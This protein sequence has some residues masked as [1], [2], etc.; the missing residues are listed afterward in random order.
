MKA[1]ASAHALPVEPA[2]SSGRSLLEV[3]LSARLVSGTSTRSSEASGANGS[4]AAEDPRASMNG[5][6]D[7]DGV[8]VGVLLGL[9]GSQP[10]LT[11]HAKPAS[12]L[13]RRQLVQHYWGCMQ[14]SS[15]MRSYNSVFVQ[16]E[17]VRTH[18]P[19]DIAPGGILWCSWW[20]AKRHKQPNAQQPRGH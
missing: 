11:W 6:A 14:D 1:M 2:I 17:H 19:V 7:I 5:P 12:T 13:E 10:C 3:R 20:L 15:R 16:L 9:I 8:E 18:L 4:G